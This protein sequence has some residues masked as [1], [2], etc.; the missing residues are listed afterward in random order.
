MDGWV[1]GYAQLEPTLLP[2][3]KAD[4]HGQKLK[5]NHDYKHFFFVYFFFFLLR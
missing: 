3:S 5:L 2:A 1:V 4:H